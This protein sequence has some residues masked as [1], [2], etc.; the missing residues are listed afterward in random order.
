MREIQPTSSWVLAGGSINRPAPDDA[1]A[2]IVRF[3]ARGRRLL[4][5]VLTLV[6]EIESSFAEIVGAEELKRV[7]RRCRV[8][9]TSWTRAARS[10]AAT[11]ES[12]GQLAKDS[13]GGTI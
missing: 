10:V 13:L 11:S 1:R 5:T 3:T 4:A 6:E 8:L 2:T 12:A 9:P 7:T